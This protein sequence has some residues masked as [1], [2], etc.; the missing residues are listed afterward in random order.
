VKRQVIGVMQDFNIQS[1]HNKIPPVCFTFMPGNYEGYLCVRLKG[2]DMQG[3]I[4]Q[5]EA[6]WKD[7]TNRQPFQYS[8]FDEEFNNLYDTEF[9][10]GKLFI[11]FSVLAI[12]IACLGLTGLIMYMTTI[13]TKEIGI[14]KTYGGTENSVIFL[15]SREVINLIVISSIVAYPIAFF[16]IRFWLETFAEKTKVTPLIYL[17]T[18]LIGLAIGWF[19]IMFHALRAAR[20]NPAEALRYK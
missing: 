20:T 16:G 4:R 19:S 15:F 12:F 1:M 5:I 6:L 14:R 2:Q 17:L 8:F 13:R 3:T 11:V 7:Y 10:A 18:S 9:R